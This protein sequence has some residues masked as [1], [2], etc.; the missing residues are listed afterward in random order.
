MNIFN[1]SDKDEII[2]AA[3]KEALSL[4]HPSCYLDVRLLITLLLKVADNKQYNHMSKSKLATIF[5]LY[6]VRYGES[7]SKDAEK[8]YFEA[9]ASCFVLRKL[10]EF[11][12]LLF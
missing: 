2:S 9:S 7:A 12:N 11:Y 1:L 8:L 3:L 6:L 5:C 10:L 4:L